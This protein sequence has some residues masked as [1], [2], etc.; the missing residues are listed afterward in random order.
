M[1]RLVAFL[2][3]DTTRRRSRRRS[4]AVW[5]SIN[6]PIVSAQHTARWS[7][8]RGNP[9]QSPT[10][11][12]EYAPFEATS[13]FF[14]EGD[15]FSRSFSRTLPRDEMFVAIRE[16]KGSR[17]QKHYSTSRNIGCPMRFLTADYFP[18]RFSSTKICNLFRIF[19]S[20]VVVD[21]FIFK[22]GVQK[23][24]TILKF[25]KMKILTFINFAGTRI[26][27][28]I[29]CIEILVSSVN[30]KFPPQLRVEIFFQASENIG[31]RTAC[32]SIGWVCMELYSKLRLR[33]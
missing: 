25:L 6:Q 33:H 29:A 2:E 20:E 9:R 17:G 15:S 19:F 1:R 27:S 26:V 31:E 32:I 18:P 24:W 10:R 11:A 16:E 23:T 3:I 14:P 7:T 4:A 30:W 8:R 5:L 21:N 28:I 13:S 22:R 12:R